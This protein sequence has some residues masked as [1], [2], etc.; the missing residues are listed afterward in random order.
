[1]AINDYCTNTEIKAVMPD[2]TWSTTYDTLFTTL[3]TRASRAIDRFT[4]R[5]PGAYKV[6]TDVTLYFDGSGTDVLE[7]EELA[8]APTSVAVAETGDLT[9]L[10]TWASTDYLL[11]PYNALDRY[12]PY[13]RLMVDYFNG[14][15]AAW[16]A[17]PKAVKVVGKFGYTTATPDDVKQATII[18]AV[19]W[20]KRGQQSFK[21]T[22][23][24]V[25]LGQLQY[26]QALDPDVAQLLKHL[27]RVTL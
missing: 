9:S 25:E 3:A 7:I 6:D 4:E 16:Y 18:Q 10:T 23:A 20:F 27:R 1:M 15:K 8:A 21:D 11:H 26:T 22:G 19:R 13:T 24:I 14:L 5:K 17:Y 12:E 2:Q